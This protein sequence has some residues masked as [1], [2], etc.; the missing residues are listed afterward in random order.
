MGSVFSASVVRVH[1]D[2]GSRSRARVVVNNRQ[3][4][5]RPHHGFLSLSGNSSQIWPHW[6]HWPRVALAFEEKAMELRAPEWPGSK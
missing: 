3:R 5:V 6:P 4:H 2:A 1:L